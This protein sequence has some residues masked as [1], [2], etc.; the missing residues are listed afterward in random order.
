MYQTKLE[1]L[2]DTDDLNRART[3]MITPALARQAGD[4]IYPRYK[5]RSRFIRNHTPEEYLEFLKHQK[6]ANSIPLIAKL[7]TDIKNNTVKPNIGFYLTTD[8]D[9]QR[10]NKIKNEALKSIPVF[11][12]KQEAFDY[13]KSLFPNDTV[14]P[15]PVSNE[16]K[17]V[18]TITK[19]KKDAKKL[20]PKIDQPTP[21][22]VQA[23]ATI[24][25]NNKQAT[26]HQK[27]FK[28]IQTNAQKQIY[29]E[30]IKSK[31]LDY[32]TLQEFPRAQITDITFRIVP[33]QAP[34]TIE[35][36]A[37]FKAENCVINILRNH[38]NVDKVYTK[39]P[40][41]KPSPNQST[42]IYITDEQLNQIAR[43]TDRRIVTY[44]ALGAKINKPWREFGHEKRTKIHIK[45]SAEHATILQNSQLIDEIIYETNLE[46]PTTTDI[47]DRGFYMVLDNETQTEVEGEP[48]FYTKQT[49]VNL[50]P[51]RTSKHAQ[52]PSTKY[53][54]T[55][56]KTFRPSSVTGNSAD[57]SNT[58]YAYV[59][60]RDQM[61]FTIF[62]EQNKLAPIENDQIKHIVKEAEH[63]IGRQAFEKISKF[64]EEHDQ[65]K[66]YISYEALNEYIGFPSNMLA[67]SKLEHAAPH[68]I[69]F[70]VINSIS[71][72]TKIEQ[73]FLRYNSE[74][75]ANKTTA[76]TTNSSIVLIKPVY[77][78]L[79]STGHE[80]DV[81]Y[82]LTTSNFTKVSIV[83][84][85]NQFNIPEEE[86]KLFRNSLVG[87]TITG[88]LKETQPVQIKY[89]N[90]NELQQLIHE[91][92]QNNFEFDYQPSQRE[93]SG[94]FSAYIPAKCKALFSFHTYI[95]GYAM[96]HM[97][98]KAAELTKNGD[99]IIGFNVDAL[100]TESKSSIEHNQDAFG[101][102]KK[103]PVKPYFTKMN[104]SEIEY[105]QTILPELRIPER[106]I[107]ARNTLIVGAAG[108]GK[109]HI[110]KVD[111]AYDQIIL[112]PTR[113]LRNEHQ[114]LFPNTHTAH[115]YFQFNVTDD[116]WK[117]LRNSGKIPQFH[118]VIVL[119]EFT[120]FT[121]SQ[122]ETIRR[123]AEGATIIALGDFQ[124]IC[125]NIDSDAIDLE[126]FEDFDQL[127][128][129]RSER[130]RHGNEYGSV[131]DS[132]R[133]LSFEEQ[134][135]KAKLT[136]KSKKIEDFS[137][138]D[139]KHNIVVGNHV[140]ANRYNKFMR[141]KLI[142]SGQKSTVM[143]PFSEIK[144]GNIGK[145]V[146]YLP[147]DTQGVFWDRKSMRDDNKGYKFEPYFA[148]TSDS[149][150]GKTVEQTLYVDVES[151]S[152]HGTFYTAI[153]R[154]RA[155][156][157]VV[158]MESSESD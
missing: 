5:N 140:V 63:F 59:F 42:P 75:G 134:S 130:S 139:L 32:N 137:I 73:A 31:I 92:Q 88:G 80:M 85:T 17:N 119:D 122:W 147:V 65:N 7:S 14:V 27:G 142:E 28:L 8:T 115:K 143:F 86:K 106:K 50:P 91:C 58:E 10:L 154:T 114:R 52:M 2:F 103:Q 87:R 89:L 128:H 37:N 45:V 13:L 123:R 156:E 149:F 48:K 155:Q 144:K 141:E 34:A 30:Q 102:W 117:L 97:M 101:G 83:D 21:S 110:W 95:L 108:T 76:A 33:E 56:Y 35:R 19:E 61:L 96:I 49:L 24:M 126:Y 112:T 120:M 107:P 105:K 64:A 98:R 12:T 69:A 151:L 16:I 25:N 38:S 26:I 51:K 41:L 43:L 55:M 22:Y 23:V 125:N 67:P 68:Q 84:F 60:T 3:I 79:L 29:L 145:K 135:A 77:D 71:N 129:T 46:I 54:N 111:P 81:E 136:F 78:Y 109:S 94:Y 131:L 18:K 62:K 47:V 118:G 150:Q 39:F 113:L 124:Q 15:Q 9:E 74:I 11:T 152:R 157:N 53:I 146:V 4:K 70:Y 104:P 90:K 82:V 20:T 40:S 1:R 6:K 116:H 93:N 66:N 148:V 72:L 153:T 132:F 138:E 127:T 100:I 121:K 57:D 99:K 133:G 44:T 158:L 36:V